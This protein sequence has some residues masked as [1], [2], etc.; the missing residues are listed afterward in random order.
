MAARVPRAQ[1]W[2][3]SGARGNAEVLRPDSCFPVAAM[4]NTPRI[5]IRFQGAGLSKGRNALKTFA[6]DLLAG[7]AADLGFPAAT[8]SVLF[9]SEREIHRLNSAFRGVDAP[10]DVLSFPAE[11]DPAALAGQDE[12]HLGDIAICLPYTA[13]TVAEHNRTLEEVVAL[14]LV[15][16]LLHLLGR[17]HDTK[18][19]EAAMWREQDA[20]LD[21]FAG[22]PRPRIELAAGSAP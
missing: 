14:L 8:V 2:L 22:L 11:E 12:P 15:H 3:R 21:A 10:T 5:E 9:C 7:A 16:G 20:L 4:P 6:R 19:R 1:A 17:D 13:R 18:P